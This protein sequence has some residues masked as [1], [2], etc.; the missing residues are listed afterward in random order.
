MSTTTS[1]PPRNVATPRAYWETRARKFARRRSGLAA[2]CSYG[3]PQFYNAH[4]DLLQRLALTPLLDA[5][6]PGARVLDVGCGVG[7]W[8]RWLARRGADVVG[9]D[10]SQAMIA[11]ARRRAAEDGVAHRCRFVVADATE[12]AL[13]AR[14]DCILCVT[15]LQHVL[16]DDRWESAIGNLAAHLAPEGRLVLLEAAPSRPNASCDSASFTA[17]PEGTHRRAFQRAGLRC[18]SV[19]GVDPAPFKIAF[20]PLYRRLP[21]P[22]A[23]PILLAV[24]AASLLVDAVAARWLTDASWH[25]TFVLARSEDDILEAAG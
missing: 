25:K 14:F 4:I 16:D 13:S 11:E 6:P 1:L 22:V 15:V 9:V 8:S 20:L 3:M 2:V 18:L 23:V 5:I 21:A 7:R 24:T 17:R 10:L 19:G 12:L